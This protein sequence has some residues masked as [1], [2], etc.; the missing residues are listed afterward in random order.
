MAVPHMYVRSVQAGAVARAFIGDPA[1][2]SKGGG[3]TSSQYMSKS[4]RSSRPGHRPRAHSIVLGFHPHLRAHPAA[5][6]R[7][8]H[9]QCQVVR[10]LGRFGLF[11]SPIDLPVVSAPVGMIDDPVGIEAILTLS[12]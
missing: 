1:T 7:G 8:G 9:P 11:K 5:G 4:Q 2:L 10:M 3:L 6:I 12:A